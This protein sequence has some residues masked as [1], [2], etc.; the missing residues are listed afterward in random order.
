MAT[1]MPVLGRKMRRL[2]K[3]IALHLGDLLISLSSA[4]TQECA[5]GLVSCAASQ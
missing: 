4:T 2:V 1:R 5:A 3:R